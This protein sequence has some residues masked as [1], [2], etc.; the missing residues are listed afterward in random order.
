M[1]YFVLLLTSMA[2]LAADKKPAPVQATNGDIDLTA[3]VMLD[4]QDI[5]QALGAD[6]GKGYI[7]VRLKASPKTGKPVWIGPEDFTL[8]SHKNGDR[9]QAL[10][11]G[12]IAGGGGALVVKAAAEQPGGDG[13]ATNGPVWGGVAAAKGKNTAGNR[14]LLEQLRQ[15]ILPGKQTQAPLEG[16]L[17]FEIDGK[18]KP[19]DLTLLYHGTAGRVAL[20]FK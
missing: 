10:A 6:L 18:L 14:A 9:C 11:P 16:L 20:D 12:Q 8:L 15:K 5:R 3:T 13:T 17:Y 19:K 1:K 2:L 4:Q 7:V